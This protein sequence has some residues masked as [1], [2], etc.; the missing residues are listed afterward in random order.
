MWSDKPQQT[1]LSIE[2]PAMIIRRESATVYC[3]T[4]P[5]ILETRGD[6]VRNMATPRKRATKKDKDSR[7]NMQ[8]EGKKKVK[9]PQKSALKSCCFYVLLISIAL[10]IAAAAYV[11]FLECP[12][13]PQPMKCVFFVRNMCEHLLHAHHVCTIGF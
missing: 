4:L 1:V 12:Y 6:S 8:D 11:W 3:M 10:V 7:S 5:M 13:E 2:R 9:T